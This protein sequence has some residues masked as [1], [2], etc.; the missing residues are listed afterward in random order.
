ML[1]RRYALGRVILAAAGLLAL[2][3]APAAASRSDPGPINAGNTYKWGPIAEDYD[4]EGSHLYGDW[5]VDGSGGIDKGGYGMLSL[6]PAPDG[7]LSATL[8]SAGHA[9]G[10]WEVRVRARFFGTGTPYRL[11]TELV[12]AA[13]N[14]Y[15]CG[16]ENIV[17]GDTTGTDPTIGMSVRD[18][19]T[20]WDGSQPI[21][22]RPGHFHTYGVEVTPDHV[23]WFI[24]SHVVATEDGDLTPGVPLTMRFAMEPTA[25]TSMQGAWLQYDWARYWTLDSPDRLSL[26]APDLV[27]TNYTGACVL[28]EPTDDPGVANPSFF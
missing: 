5:T 4:F 14:P 21:D 15:A 24:D 9:Y 25:G 1:V 19:G 17:F 13:P 12:P 27:P 7:A 3:I 8:D 10:R 28:S 18:G 20:E 16:S 26:A 23:S 6:K 2:S 11:L 22:I